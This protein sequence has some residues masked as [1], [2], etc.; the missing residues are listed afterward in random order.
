MADKCRNISFPTG[1][2]GPYSGYANDIGL[3][4][5]SLFGMMVAGAES[6]DEKVEWQ[7]VK[8]KGAA[9]ARLADR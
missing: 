6:N 8:E 4:A 5:L 7:K 2:Q 1:K 3:T 9:I